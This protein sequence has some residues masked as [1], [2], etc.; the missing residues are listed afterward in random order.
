MSAPNESGGIAT[1]SVEEAE[2]RQA[3]E[4]SS[5]LIDVREMDEYIEL[6]P[7]RSAFMP[8]S[9]LGGRFSELPQDQPL[10]LICLSG[11]RSARATAFLTQQ[12]FAD[13][14]NVEGG[15]MAWK[16][17]DLP[18]RAGPLDSGEGDL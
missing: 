14:S 15:M 18:M 5:L 2:R 11:G 12:G 9:Q 16:R 6:R 17:A 3:D 10:M 13:V 7:E 1:I 8:M 4:P